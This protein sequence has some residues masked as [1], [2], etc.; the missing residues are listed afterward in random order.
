[1]IFLAPICPI[2]TNSV[3][4]P[5]EPYSLT[6]CS[7]L[8]AAHNEGLSVLE[9]CLLVAVRQISELT[10]GEPFNFEMVY[11]GKHY[12]SDMY[13]LVTLWYGGMCRI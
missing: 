2:G 5:A 13:L 12:R 4:F 8:C 11:S 9:L 7:W 10:G 6:V 3:A 1:M